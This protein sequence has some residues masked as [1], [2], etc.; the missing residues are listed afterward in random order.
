MPSGCAADQYLPTDYLQIRKAAA[1][2]LSSQ[3][4]FRENGKTMPFQ[5]SIRICL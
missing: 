4:E 1:I 5:G 2:A 3:Q